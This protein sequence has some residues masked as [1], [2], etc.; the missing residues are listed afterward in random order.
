MTNRKETSLMR[1]ER[2]SNVSTISYRSQFRTL[3]ILQSN[4]IVLC[5]RPITCL[6]VDSWLDNDVRYEFH[7]EEWNLNPSG[8]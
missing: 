1:I 6:L 3:S 8:K 5:P 4:S 7:L 2:S